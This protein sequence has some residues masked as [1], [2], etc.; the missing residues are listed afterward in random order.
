MSSPVGHVSSDSM[1]IPSAYAAPLVV[2]MDR[3]K[4]ELRSSGRPWTEELEQFR[5]GLVAEARFH[6]RRVPLV[7]GVGTAP[8]LPF[9]VTPSQRGGTARMLTVKQAALLSGTSDRWVRKLAVRGKLPAQ[10]SSDGWLF[11]GKDV[12]EWLQ[13]RKTA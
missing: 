4:A 3:W 9:S 11:K 2:L 12:Q 13:S 8:V 1:V 5:L 6:M 7:P 10:R